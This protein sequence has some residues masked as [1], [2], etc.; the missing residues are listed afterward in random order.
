MPNIERVFTSPVDTCFSPKE[1]LVELSG[2]AP[3][4]RTIIPHT[5]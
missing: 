2:A 5:V 4:S 1:I 3:E